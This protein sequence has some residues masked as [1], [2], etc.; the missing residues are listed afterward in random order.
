MR[1]NPLI[2]IITVVFNGVK[3]IEKTILSVINQTYANIEYIIIDGG[4]SDE[5]VDIIKANESMIDYWVSE[6]DS[7]IYDAMNKGLKQASGDFVI[8]MNGGDQFYTNDTLKKLLKNVNNI[9]KVYFGRAKNY[10]ENKSW[11]YPNEKYNQN[12]IDKWLS[13]ALPNH[14]AMIFPKCFYKKYQYNLEYKI[15]SDSDYK[16]YAQKEC[17]FV[18]V[19]MTIC[20][21]EIGGISSSFSNFKHLRQILKDSWKISTNHMDRVYALKRFFKIVLKYILN[22]IKK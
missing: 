8:F 11:V 9:D 6:K 7:G 16:F 19:D 2:S 4:S 10:N 20:E 15:G 17:G 21:F 1:D 12:N 13:F 3:N 18:F 5:T 22:L 14:Q